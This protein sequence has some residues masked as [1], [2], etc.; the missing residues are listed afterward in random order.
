MRVFP[1]NREGAKELLQS[2]DTYA[3]T[4]LTILLTQYE[5]EEVLG[6]DAE[7]AAL[8]ANVEEDFGVKLPEENENRIQAAILV[9]TSDLPLISFPVFR[10]CALAFAEGQIGDEEDREDGDLN[11]CELLWALYEMALL[12]GVKVEEVQEELS[13]EVVEKLNEVIDSEAE[14]VEEEEE[15][16]SKEEGIEDINEVARDPYYRRYVR[17]S[18]EELVRQLRKLEVS[19]EVCVELLTTYNGMGS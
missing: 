17:A 12:L 15:D 16:E 18:L 14:D 4:L 1:Y 5:T 9:L 11:T 2:S 10:S 6:E 19:P 3:F 8:F 7:V 13:E